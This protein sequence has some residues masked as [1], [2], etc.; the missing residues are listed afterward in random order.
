LEE[1]VDT[2]TGRLP[3]PGESLPEEAQG[4]AANQQ[5]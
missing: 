1:R 5:E 3:E 4:E 2:G